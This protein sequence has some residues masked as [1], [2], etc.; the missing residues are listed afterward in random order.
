MNLNLNEQE[1]NFILQVLGEL[2]T[3]SGAYPLA[4]NIKQQAE[5]QLQTSTPNDLAKELTKKSSEGSYLKAILYARL[6]LTE[7]AKDEQE[8]LREELK[9]MLNDLTYEK[10]VES[11]KNKITNS[12]EVYKQVPAAIM[13]G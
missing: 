2:P 11:D 1:V 5:Q 13:V 4:M 3:K 6:G 7:L 10:L 12:V 8:K 9:T